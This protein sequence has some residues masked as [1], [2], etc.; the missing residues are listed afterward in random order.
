MSYSRR[1]QT[2][3]RFA[4][5]V[6]QPMS[7]R[8][9]S[10]LP[11]SLRP[12]VSDEERFKGLCDG[13]A[14]ANLHAVAK[15]VRDERADLIVPSHPLYSQNRLLAVCACKDSNSVSTLPLFL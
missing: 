2:F 4:F 11:A 10:A 6:S 12:L 5:R 8:P 7:M 14:A 15:A 1:C 3:P 13:L 9:S